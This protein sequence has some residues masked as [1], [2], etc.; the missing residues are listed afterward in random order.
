MNAS[1]K[2]KLLLFKEDKKPPQPPYALLVQ[3][4]DDSLRAANLMGVPLMSR[5]LKRA[6]LSKP[7]LKRKVAA[8]GCDLDKCV[9]LLAVNWAARRSEKGAK[10][11][12]SIAIAP[13]PCLLT[14]RIQGR[15]FFRYPKH[16]GY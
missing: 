9:R 1:G 13:G 7:E 11:I 10:R 2:M 16:H 3:L 15:S 5:S 12:N 14:D 8:V 4:S 6:I